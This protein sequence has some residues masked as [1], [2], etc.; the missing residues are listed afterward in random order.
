[1]GDGWSRGFVQD[2]RSSNGETCVIYCKSML[3]AGQ[4]LRIGLPY[5]SSRRC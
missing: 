1:M 2:F 3:S 4:G 5:R